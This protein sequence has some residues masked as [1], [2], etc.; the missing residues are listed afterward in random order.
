M[1]Y[2]NRQQPITTEPNKVLLKLDRYRVTVIDDLGYVKRGNA[3][4]GVLFPQVRKGEPDHYEQSSVWHLLQHLRGRKKSGGGGRQA[5]QRWT[6]L[7]G[8]RRKPQQETSKSGNTMV[9]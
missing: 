2:V 5:D 4:I 1:R 8:N 3:E 7:R 6:P 9:R